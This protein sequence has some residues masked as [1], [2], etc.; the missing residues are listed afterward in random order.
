MSHMLPNSWHSYMAHTSNLYMIR[1]YISFL[2]RPSSFWHIS[3]F[4]IYKS[5]KIRLRFSKHMLQNFHI[6]NLSFSL[7]LWKSTLQFTLENQFLNSKKLKVKK[8]RHWYTEKESSDVKNIFS[9]LQ[10]EKYFL[11]G[12]K[13]E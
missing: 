9:W 8:C 3:R 10:D 4:P 11:K 6:I 7:I 2:K 12:L 1:E 13:S 5:F